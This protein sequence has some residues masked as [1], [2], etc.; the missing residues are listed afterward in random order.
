MGSVELQ[1]VSVQQL[2][3]C[4]LNRRLIRSCSRINRVSQVKGKIEVRPDDRGSDF[5]F[6]TQDFWLVDIALEDSRFF[7][8]G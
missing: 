1:G 3:A 5:V 7:G 6:R 8:V 4:E 2:D